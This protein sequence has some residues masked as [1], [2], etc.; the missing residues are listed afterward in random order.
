MIIVE[1]KCWIADWSR[2]MGW[3]TC[4]MIAKAHAEI[5]NSSLIYRGVVTCYANLRVRSGGKVFIAYPVEK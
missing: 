1:R 3:A 2:W 5:D 4:E